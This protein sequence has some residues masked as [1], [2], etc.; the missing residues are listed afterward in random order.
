LITYVR[1][2]IAE[3]EINLFNFI[4]DKY[5]SLFKDIVINNI[6][7]NTGFRNYKS[8]ISK[9]LSNVIV[10]CDRHGYL[11]FRQYIDN[12]RIIFDG[13]KIKDNNT[14]GHGKF[15]VKKMISIKVFGQELTNKKF[16]DIIKEFFLY[17]F[18]HFNYA[19]VMK[20]K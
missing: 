12:E 20:N 16:N 9:M 13:L 1:E 10:R 11:N 5:D 7:I 14:F 6:K 4:M 8:I 17:L 19:D 3:N 18:S 15:N 2:L